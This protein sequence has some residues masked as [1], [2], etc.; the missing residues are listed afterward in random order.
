MIPRWTWL[1]VGLLGGCSADAGPRRYTVSGTVTYAGQPVPTGEVRF[2]PDPEQGARGPGA[3]ARIQGGRFR[4][5][6]GWGAI[7]GPH[8][9][10]VQAGSGR[11]ASLAD[12]VGD[13]LIPGEHR[14]KL[15]LPNADSTQ[16]I[17]IPAR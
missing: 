4:T 2:E 17:V 3:F 10:R 6:P 15:V 11:N 9:V 12:P 16:E 8:W 7:A 1:L 5:E 13:P 14:T